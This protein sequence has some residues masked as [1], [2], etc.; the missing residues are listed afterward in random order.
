MQLCFFATSSS[1]S[2]TF[3]RD[4]SPASSSSR[5]HRYFP[6][7]CFTISPR[8]CSSDGAPLAERNIWADTPAASSEGRSS[9][10]LDHLEGQEGRVHVWRG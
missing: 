2:V 3:A 4:E 10:G 7:E 6:L 8:W 9:T 5:C 1:L